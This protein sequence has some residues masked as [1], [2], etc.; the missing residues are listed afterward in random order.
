MIENNRNI[1]KSIKK[2]VVNA[3][4]TGVIHCP[5]GYEVTREDCG[6]CSQCRPSLWY[7]INSYEV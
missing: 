3:R 2:M 5:G 7:F 1:N 4:K 6:R